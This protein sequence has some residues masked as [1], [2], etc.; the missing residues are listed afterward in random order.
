[1]LLHKVLSTSNLLKHYHGRHKGI[2]TSS[3]KAKKLAINPTK[4]NFFCKY[5]TGLGYNK[6]CK[7][8]LNLIVSNNLQLSL[9]ESPLFQ[10]FIIGYNLYV[11]IYIYIY[12][13][14]FI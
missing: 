5:D 10:A 13:N 9:V 8:A 12:S 4:P 2:T 6:A 14:I 7:L 1:M 11:L 3:N